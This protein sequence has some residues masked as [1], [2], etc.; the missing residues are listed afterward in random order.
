MRREGDVEG[1]RSGGKQ[2][3]IHKTHYSLA[4]ASTHDAFYSFIS[5]N[6]IMI[7]T[8]SPPSL[9]LTLSPPPPFPPPPLVVGGARAF[10]CLS[11]PKWHAK[12]SN[13]GGI[14]LFFIINTIQYNI[15]DLLK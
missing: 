13:I 7:S 2:E 5:T 15:D 9:T 8:F 12:E 14:L 1:G 3:A 6:C 4:G 10:L 11:R